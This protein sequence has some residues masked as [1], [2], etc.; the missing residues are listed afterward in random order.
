MRKSLAITLVSTLLLTLVTVAPAMAEGRGEWGA[1]HEFH[2]GCVGCG[3][4]GGL[5]LGGVLGG[6]LAAPYVAPPPVYAAPPPACYTQPGYWGRAP[7]VRPDGY[8]DYRDV[9]VPPQTMCQ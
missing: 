9:W 2:H 8:T 1:R 3:F 5:V 4:L 6:A 7:Y